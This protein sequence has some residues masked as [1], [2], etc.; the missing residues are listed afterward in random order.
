MI[1]QTLAVDNKKQQLQAESD[2]G[3]KHNN[4]V[5]YFVHFKTSTSFYSRNQNLIKTVPIRKKR[6]KKATM[7]RKVIAD[8]EESIQQERLVNQDT[9]LDDIAKQELNVINNNGIKAGDNTDRSDGN[10]IRGLPNIQASS[11]YISSLIQVLAQTPGFIDKLFTARQNCHVAETLI[12]L[13]VE[14]N[15]IQHDSCYTEEDLYNLVSE[16]QNSM[17]KRDEC[18]QSGNQNDCHSLYLSL[19]SALDEEIEG[20]TSLFDAHARQIFRYSTCDHVEECPPECTRSLLLTVD[21]KYCS[22]NESIKLLD[23]TVAFHDA[24]VPC[25]TCLKE[26]KHYEDTITFKH[27]IIESPAQILVLQ[28]SR[29]KQDVF[30]TDEPH[31][32]LYKYAGNVMYPTELTLLVS[33]QGPSGRECARVWYELYGVIC[34]EGD[35]DQGHYW[36]YVKK[37]GWNPDHLYLWHLCAD[38]Y[39]RRLE[40][41]E[42][43]PNSPFAYL[44]F[45]KQIQSTQKN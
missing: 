3:R 5:L 15:D 21:D 38:S 35:L 32:R 16:L 17:S 37:Y 30:S 36:C 19:L 22:V 26:E 40:I 12:K 18:Y 10:L 14:I 45:Y 25:R 4:A 33:K 43:W 28:L 6:K 1:Q 20:C 7:Q 24:Q 8:N 31:G 9:A 11:C 13:F 27:F 23:E 2:T 34:H 41:D 44:L 42:E 29:F 39:V